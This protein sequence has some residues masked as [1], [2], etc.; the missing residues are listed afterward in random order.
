MAERKSLS[1]A[2]SMNPEKLAFI[3]QGAPGSQPL[4]SPNQTTEPH[5]TIELQTSTST[6]VSD[7]QP[8]TKPARSQSRARAT[9]GALPDANEI[10]DQVLVPVTIRL[11]HRTSQALRRAYLQ[12]RLNHAKPDTQQEI[13]EIAIQEWLQKEGYL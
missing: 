9:R 12:Q 7:Q 8:K 13:V 2:M 6:D 3:K 5:K 1:D 11:Q 4:Q 10:L